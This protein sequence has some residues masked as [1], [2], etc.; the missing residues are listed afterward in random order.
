M[1]RPVH[2]GPGMSIRSGIAGTGSSSRPEAR[3]S[4][5]RRATRPARVT[6]GV[7]FAGASSSAA[8]SIAELT[9]CT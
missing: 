3:G 7:Y 9:C 2:R 1:A 6:A 8:R 5:P 4:L